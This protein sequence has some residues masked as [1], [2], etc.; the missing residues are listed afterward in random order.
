MSWI[1]VSVYSPDTLSHTL[2]SSMSDIYCSLAFRV[3]RLGFS[4]ST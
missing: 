3:L 2:A 4:I 1:S